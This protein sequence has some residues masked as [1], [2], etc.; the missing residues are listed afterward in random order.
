MFSV[1]KEDLGDGVI[2]H[3]KGSL[4][5]GIETSLLCAAVGHYGQDVVLDLSQVT[6]IDAAG[7]G[8]LIALQTAG[9]YLKLQNPTRHV[10]EI[11]HVTGL[12]SIFEIRETEV[13]VLA[14]AETGARSATMTACCSD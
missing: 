1:T 8:A 12:E 7:I 9:V 13:P 4:V 2:L 6:T 10:R 3:C 11:L 14:F 5:R